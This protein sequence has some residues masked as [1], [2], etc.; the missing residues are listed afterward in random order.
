MATLAE[1]LEQK[2]LLFV[3]KA[4]AKSIQWGKRKGNPSI[5]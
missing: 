3:L 2:N 4:K 1:Y 5:E